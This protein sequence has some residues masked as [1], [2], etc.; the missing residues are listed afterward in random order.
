M[1]S[2]RT[3]EEKYKAN[4]HRNL[5]RICMIQLCAKAIKSPEEPPTG[6]NLALAKKVLNMPDTYFE[7]IYPLVLGDDKVEEGAPDHVIANAIEEALKAFV[8]IGV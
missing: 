8:D 5:I 6:V 2:L 7:K 4:L 1:A 3:I